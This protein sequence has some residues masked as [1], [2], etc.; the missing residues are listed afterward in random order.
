[1]PR[2]AWMTI[3]EGQLG[4]T[5]TAGPKSNP[6]ILEWGKRVGRKLGIAYTDD[7]TPWCGLFVGMCIAQAGLTPPDIAVRAKSWATWGDGLRTPCEGAVLVFERPGGGHVGFYVSE[8]PDAF[9]V[10]GGNQGDKVSKAWIAKDRCVAMR[11]PSGV[12]VTGKRIV[13]AA[14]GQPVSVNEA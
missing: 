10:L 3:A 1:M 2:P 6:K 7:A 14:N 5:E 11:W 4:V 12:P 8:R 9:L 13:L